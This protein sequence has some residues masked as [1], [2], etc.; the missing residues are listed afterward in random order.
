MPL[1]LVYLLGVLVVFIVLGL[2]LFC[3]IPEKIDKYRIRRHL[4][5]EGSQ[6]ISFEEQDFGPGWIDAGVSA[7][8][9][10]VTFRTREGDIRKRICRIG[11]LSG[12]YWH[13]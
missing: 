8:I 2:V 3:V 1:E 7:R 6:V 9:W 5:A 12:I 4:S 10:E 11:V 13:N